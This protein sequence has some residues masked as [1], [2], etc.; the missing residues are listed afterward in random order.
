MGPLE[1][2]RIIDLTTVVMGPFATQIL[3]DFGADV[4]KVEAP[5]G[6]M[7]RSIGPGKTPG[8]GALFMNANRSKRSITLDI[9]QAAGRE[10]F[11]RLCADADVL[12]CNVRPAAMERLHLGYEDLLKVNPKLIYAALVGYGETGPYAGR[13]AYDDLIQGATT[14]PYIYSRATGDEPRF[15]PSAVADRIVALY[16]IGAITSA[17]V[18]RTRTDKGQRISIPMFETMTA[19]MMGDH[20]GGLTF[21]PPLDSGGYSRQLSPYRRPY[22]TSDGYLCTAIFADN[23]WARFLEAIGRTDLPRTDPRF[24]DF[25][26][27]YAHIDEVNGWLY[28]IFQ[29]RPTA[30]WMDL[31]IKA[32]IPVT[33]MHDFQSILTDPHLEATGFFRVS[34]HPTEGRIRE[35]AVPASFSRSV[36]TPSRPTPQQGAQGTEILHEIGYGD[37]EIAQLRAAGVLG[38]TTSGAESGVARAEGQAAKSDS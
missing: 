34:E 17:L 8:M 4:I 36:P 7:L 24:A 32:D 11:L 18:E 13:P 37:D 5:E 3:G 30:E 23:H 33:P 19:F 2:I 10:A 1:G 14:L 31:L 29:T 15:V 12:V 9:K 38:T 26:S 22:K 16:A 35:M 6:D 21:D 27:R 28:D 25:Q 20:M